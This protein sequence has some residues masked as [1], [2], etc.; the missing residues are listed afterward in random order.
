MGDTLFFRSLRRYVAGNRYGNVTTATFQAVCERTFNRPL[1]WFFKEWVYG[2][3]L[4]AYSLKWTQRR[5]ARGFDV[6]VTVEQTQEGAVFTMPVDLLL[7]TTGADLHKVSMDDRRTISARFSSAD[8]VT[9]V[10]LDP[11][12]WILRRSSP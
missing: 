9:A 7:H 2:K 4:P 6:D 11:G 5:A 8:S 12:N 3:G 1:D 10:S